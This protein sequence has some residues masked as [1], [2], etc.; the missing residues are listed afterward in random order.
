VNDDPV[1]LSVVGLSADPAA[2]AALVSRIVVKYLERRRQRASLWRGVVDHAKPAI[3]LAAAGVLVAAA[4]S[5][6]A[7]RRPAVVT[8]L[9]IPDPVERWMMSPAMPTSLEVMIAMAEMPR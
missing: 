9:A 4:L 3:A 7:A 2:R 8:T 6:A 5:A 1:D